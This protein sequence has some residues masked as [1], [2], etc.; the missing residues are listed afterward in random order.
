MLRHSLATVA[1]RL[2]HAVHGA[3]EDFGTFRVAEGVRTPVDIL[4][5]MGDLMDWALSMA[6]GAMQW[7]DSAPLEWDA[8]LE[9]FFAALDRLK[10]RLEAG[11]PQCDE[12]RLLQGP[13]ADA[14]THV[15][16][17]ALLR[18]IQGAPVR[19][20]NYFKADI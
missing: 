8:E 15:G 11:P 3:P 13:V 9:R 14:L 20:K 17:I 16:Q 2:R 7:Q 1:Y 12:K 6:D 19:P 10:D 4:A 5:H 18:R